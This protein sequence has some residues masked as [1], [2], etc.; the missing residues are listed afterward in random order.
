MDGRTPFHHPGLVDQSLVPSQCRRPPRE[1]LRNFHAIV[2]IIM[3]SHVE[4]QRFHAAESSSADAGTLGE[5]H[6]ETTIVVVSR[7]D[8]ETAITCPRFD[9]PVRRGN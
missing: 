5:V 7:F 1:S 3:F 6:M 9:D 8:G 2:F 4:I